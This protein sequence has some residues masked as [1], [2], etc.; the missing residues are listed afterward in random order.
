MSRSVSKKIG[1][2]HFKDRFPPCF[3][4]CGTV[5]SLVTLNSFVEPHGCGSSMRTLPSYIAIY[6]GD[7]N[8][9][10]H[11]VLVAICEGRIHMM[12]SWSSKGTHIAPLENDGIHI[13]LHTVHLQLFCTHVI[14]YPSHFVLVV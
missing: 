13:H 8:R 2:R 6:H 1:I 5:R 11:I 4:S 10:S 3:D 7:A 12:F 14:T 9:P